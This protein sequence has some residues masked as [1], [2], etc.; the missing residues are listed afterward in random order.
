[1]DS[2]RK[3]DPDD[4]T[5]VSVLL[6]VSKQNAANYPADTCLPCGAVIRMGFFFDA[7]GRNRDIDDPESSQ[8]SNICRLWEAHCANTDKHR[9]VKQFWYAFYYSGLGTPLNEDSDSSA[10]KNATAAATKMA[11]AKVVSTA[12]STAES[13]S[14]SFFRVKDPLEKA[15]VKSRAEK[16]LKESAK[17]FSFRPLEK[18]FEDIKKEIKGIPADARR[19][20]NVLT[21]S[22]E[23]LLQRSKAAGSLVLKGAKDDTIGALKKNPLKALGTVARSLFAGIIMENV[24][25]VRDNAFMAMYFGTGIDTRLLAAMDQFKAAY[26]AVRA[27]MPHVGVIEVSVFGADRGCVLARTFVNALAT[28][29]KQTDDLDLA[30]DGV[31]IKIKFLGL[32]DAV[33]SV[34]S[35]EASQVV[36]LVPFINVIK[37]DYKDRALDV[38]PSVE[39]CVHFAAAH[40]KRCY[41]RLDSL[42]KTRGEQFLYPGTSCDVVGGAV[43]GSLGFNAELMRIPLRDMLLEAMKAGTAI[44]SMEEMANGK[45]LTFNKFS[46]AKPIT[47]EG[48]QY[49][50][51]HLVDAYQALVPRKAGLNILDHEKIFLRWIA[52]RYQDPEFRKT[53]SDPVEKWRSDYAAADYQRKLTKSKLDAEMQRQGV[54]MSMI[55]TRPPEDQAT[56]LKLKAE[57]D[58]AETHFENLVGTAPRD[59]TSVWTRLQNDADRLVAKAGKQDQRKKTAESLRSAPPDPYGLGGAQIAASVLEYGLLSDDEMALVDAWKEGIG[60]KHPL[61]ADVMA[62]FDMLV[63]DTLLTSWQD[64]VLADTL[65]FRTRDTDTFGSTD[66]KAEDEQRKKDDQK[67]A[68]TARLAKQK[69]DWAKTMQGMPPM[70]P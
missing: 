49:R 9:P 30:I 11:T 70:L 59:F 52:V 2:Q 62:M 65:Y 12:K 69:Q 68:D 53:I 66:K 39:R 67:A 28:Q 47:C 33:S 37:T 15:D 23:R 42:E 50:V 44:N 17:E 18:A 4:A 61:P 5:P 45:P 58:A 54:I 46:I 26:N 24:P 36:G 25:I 16:A 60:G 38:P 13:V 27:Q 51:R 29:Y 31:K 3:L 20:T 35:E 56:L 7:F 19:I 10:I 63:H 43:K 34:M 8:Y 40:E 57:R 21:S 48:K 41:Q 22:S 14:K 1:M 32:L 6:Q 64:H 55:S